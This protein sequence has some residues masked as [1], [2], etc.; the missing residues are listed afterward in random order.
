MA[1]RDYSPSPQ[2]TQSI[3]QTWLT[4]YGVLGKQRK[5]GVADPYYVSGYEEINVRLPL[6]AL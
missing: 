3:A 6:H 4:G 1:P 5:A 2:G